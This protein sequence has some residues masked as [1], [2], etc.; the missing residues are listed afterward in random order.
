MQVAV[1]PVQLGAAEAMLLRRGLGEEEDGGRLELGLE[2]GLD[3][4]LEQAGHGLGS[5]VRGRAM[6]VRVG[7]G[8]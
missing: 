8:F 4:G 7:L 1:A 5:L 6:L 3:L 2:L